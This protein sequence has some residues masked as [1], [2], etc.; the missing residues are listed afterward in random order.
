MI[1]VVGT[2]IH[3]HLRHTSPPQPSLA[4]PA[5]KERVTSSA[6][7]ESAK[8][9]P[10]DVKSDGLPATT[11]E[12][13]A[14]LQSPDR[15]MS[16]SS[17]QAALNY[18]KNPKRAETAADPAAEYFNNVIALVLAQSEPVDG[19]SKVLL[20]VVGDNSQ[21]LLLRD[22]AMQHLFHVWTRESNL[23]TKREI[24]HC[25]KLNFEDVTSPLQ[26]VALLTASRLFDQRAEV[27]GPNGEKLTPIG[28]R[29][30]QNPLSIS[31]P[32]SFSGR[33]FVDSALHVTEDSAAATNARSCAFNVLLR[34]EANQAIYPARKV[35]QDARTPDDVRCAAL[36]SLGAFGDLATDRVFLDTIPVKPEFVRTAADFALHRLLKS[37]PNR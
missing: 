37:Q 25:L 21:T 28:G 9:N 11:Q 33:D 10:P 14:L 29:T 27:K 32:S 35:L 30:A 16:P 34:L 1:A 36:A 20:A 18:L 22:Y 31:K 17:L 4:K 19:L 24:E 23:Q 3:W 15:R 26:G 6:V 7:D 12:L 5:P 8:P 13:L 2:A